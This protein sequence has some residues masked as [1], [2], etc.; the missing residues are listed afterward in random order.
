MPLIDMPLEELF[1]YQ[2][3]TQ[4]PLILMNTGPGFG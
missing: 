3:A 2:A 1:Q 4:K